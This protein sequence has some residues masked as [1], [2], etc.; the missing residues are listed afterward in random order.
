MHAVKNVLQNRAIKRASNEAGEALR[1]KQFS[2]W[3]KATNG[4]NVRSDFDRKK[5]QDV[6]DLY[7][8]HPKWKTA[9]GM[10][11]R[12]LQDITDGATLYYAHKKINP[13]SWTKN[14]TQT[15]VIGGHTFGKV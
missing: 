12:Y 11:K 13:P 14:W 3:N 2:M 5:L 6:I 4:V 10:S 1:P 8:E 7:I 9:V 15:V